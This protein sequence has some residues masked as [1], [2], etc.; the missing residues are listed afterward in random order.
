M[1]KES[2]NLAI[3]LSDLQIFGHKVQGFHW[4]I[5]GPHF[6]T[7]HA[8]YEDIY[9]DVQAHIDDVAERLVA[10]SGS[11]PF[12]MQEYLKLKKLSEENHHALRADAMNH[13]LLADLEKIIM[14]AERVLKAADKDDVTTDL[15]MPM[16][17]V[18]AKYQWMLRALVS[19]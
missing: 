18:Y 15:I 7:L 17:S 16:L 6:L 5:R 4:N 19:S 11:A 2:E 13:A 8:F 14:D 1:N 12:T 3:L 10:L 9:K